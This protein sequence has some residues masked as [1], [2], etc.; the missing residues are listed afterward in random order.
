[1]FELYIRDDNGE[2][3]FQVACKTAAKLQFWIA[4]KQAKGCETYWQWVEEE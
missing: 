2:W 3:L 1:M 4:D